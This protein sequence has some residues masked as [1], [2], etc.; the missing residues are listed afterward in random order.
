MYD[1]FQKWDDQKYEF[2]EP[3]LWQDNDGKFISLD[4]TIPLGRAGNGISLERLLFRRTVSGDNG[5][6]NFNDRYFIR[7][8]LRRRKLR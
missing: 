1:N 4:H 3:A 6:N 2:I 5:F 7:H 8:S